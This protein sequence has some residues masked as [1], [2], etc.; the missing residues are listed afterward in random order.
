MTGMIQ[1]LSTKFSSEIKAKQD[2]LDVTQAHLR[3]ATRELSTDSSVAIPL[4]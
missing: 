2:S 4:C 1:S 3:A